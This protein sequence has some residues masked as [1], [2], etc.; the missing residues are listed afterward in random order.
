MHPGGVYVDCTAGAGGHSELIAQRLADGRLIALDRDPAAVELARTRLRP[1]PQAQ[2]VHANYANLASVLD[3]LSIRRVHGVL[4]DAGVSSM[5]IDDPERGFSLQNDGPLDMRMNPDEGMTALEYLAS[6]D[7]DE[8]A[9][10]LRSYGDVKPARRIAK[11]LAARAREGRIRTTLDLVRTVQESLSFVRGIPEEV[12]TVFQALRI[13]VNDELKGLSEGVHQAIDMLEPGGRL[14][15]I[16]F[17]S[18]EDRIV[19]N[20]LNRESRPERELHPDGRVKREIPPRMRILTRKPVA[21]DSDEVRENPRAHS[22]RL[23]AAE[24]LSGDMEP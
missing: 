23:R 17:H 9:D 3:G 2:V 24:R 5:Q 15:A 20:A 22:A 7:S 11:L 10:V 4:I 14:V 18:G 6:T 12:R 16:S 21:P 13:A 19:K 1:F 8:L